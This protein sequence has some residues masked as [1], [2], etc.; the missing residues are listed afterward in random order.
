MKVHTIKPD[1]HIKTNK[2]T[3]QIYDNKDG[4]FTVTLGMKGKGKPHYGGKIVIGTPT[5]GKSTE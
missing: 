5:N 1:A 3:L 4:T 2:R